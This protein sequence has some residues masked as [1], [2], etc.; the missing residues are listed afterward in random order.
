MGVSCC[1]RV[2][3]LM[4]V[5]LAGGGGA[6]VM[7]V[8]L[9]PIGGPPVSGGSPASDAVAAFAAVAWVAGGAFVI[10]TTFFGLGCPEAAAMAE[11]LA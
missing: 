4:S 10:G 11:G 2:T 7:Y 9:R 8:V 3:S 1:N 6:H 5:G